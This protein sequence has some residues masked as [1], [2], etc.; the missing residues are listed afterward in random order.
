MGLSRMTS[1]REEQQHPLLRMPT[2]MLA[3]AIMLK[4]RLFIMITSFRIQ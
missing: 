2:A 4:E 3:A 1:V